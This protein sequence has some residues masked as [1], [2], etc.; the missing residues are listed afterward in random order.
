MMNISKET[1]QKTDAWMRRNARPLELARWEYH[2]KGGSK[3]NVLDRLSAFQNE[4]GG[5]GYGLEPDFWNPHSTPMATWAAGQI[6]VEIGA[7]PD[8]KLIRPLTQ[9]LTNLPQIEPGMWPSVTPENNNYPHAFWW[10]WQ[11]GA[12]Q[13]WQ[14]NPSVELAAM[15]IHWS[16]QD[17][18]SAQIGWQTIKLA[19]EHLMTAPQMDTHEIQNFQ[20]CI[21]L[22]RPFEQTF[23]QV[24]NYQLHDVSE[25]VMQLA[26]QSIEQDPAGWGEGYQ[27]LPL[28]YITNPEHPLC[29]RL[30][31][32]VEKNIELYINEMT[33]EGIWDIS[34]DWEGFDQEFAVARR[35][36]QGILAVDRFKILRNFGCL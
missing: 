35:Q 19:V 3:E 28:N 2:F 20:Q 32:L 27:T 22:M 18:K 13:F 12:Q 7:H 29:N 30:G 21:K 25:K 4:D 14:F 26:E 33:S 1:F 11:E 17:S 31:N 10:K 15:L 6:L 9:Y 34:W 5:F 23:N 8:E 16:P 36:W 24:I